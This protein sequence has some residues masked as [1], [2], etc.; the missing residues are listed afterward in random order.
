MIGLGIHVK[1]KDDQLS[2]FLPRQ[3]DKIDISSTR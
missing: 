3:A 1:Q 2:L